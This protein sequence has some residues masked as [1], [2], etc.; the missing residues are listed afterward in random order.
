[1][2]KVN[3]F[4]LGNACATVLLFSSLSIASTV[5]DCEE[6][7]TDKSWPGDQ[8]NY[9]L[10]CNLEKVNLGDPYKGEILCI[11][12]SLTKR[13]NFQSTKF[14]AYRVGQGGIGGLLDI[15][16]KNEDGSIG[17]DEFLKETESSVTFGVFNNSFENSQKWKNE[18]KI[19][20]N[21]LTSNYNV[22]HKKGL[23]SNYKLSL[24]STYQCV[25][26]K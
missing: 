9:I 6:K 23:F 21:T 4:G 14:Q 15:V 5:V 3:L 1:M 19:D 18:I 8:Y 13:S 22:Y 24:S 16:I 17:E 11:G 10:K 20:L 7:L 12:S 26:E 2:K 25:R